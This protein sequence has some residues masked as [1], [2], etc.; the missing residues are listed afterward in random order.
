MFFFDSQIVKSGFFA[1]ISDF[2]DHIRLITPFFSRSVP[3]SGLVQFEIHYGNDSQ[4]IFNS[5]DSIINSY[6]HKNFSG[7][8][9]VVASWENLQSP[10]SNNVS[11][12]YTDKILIRIVYICQNRTTHS[13]ES[14]SLTLSHLM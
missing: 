10:T 3:E 7:E 6:Q 2:D 11:R 1:F 8:W 9:L 14:L 13:R 5:V 12:Q 4:E